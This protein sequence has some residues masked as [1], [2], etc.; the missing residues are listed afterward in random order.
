MLMNYS[1]QKS[2]TGAT[3][4]CQNYHIACPGVQYKKRAGGLS[5]S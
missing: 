1:M 4:E 3:T 5:N 2:W